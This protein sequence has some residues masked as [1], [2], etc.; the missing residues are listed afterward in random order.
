VAPPGPH[1]GFRTYYSITYEALNGTDAN[2]DD[3]FVPDNSTYCDTTGLGLIN[4]GRDPD[5]TL[6]R[7]M[8]QSGR[9]N[10]NNK[11]HNLVGPI[12]PTSS[13]AADLE[14]VGVV[15]NPYRLSAEWDLPGTNELHFTNLPKQATIRIYTVAG[16]FVRELHHSDA[17]ND[18]ERWDLKSGAGQQVAS[19]IY[20]YRVTGAS[21]S[22]QSR[23]IVIR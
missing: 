3:L 23:F 18:F 22:Y 15:P 9:P 2:Y 17:V 13:P 10:L 7:H 19:G 14:H 5:S 16:D 8:V 4:A 20:I 11:F 12:Q 1:D 6:Y 21:Y